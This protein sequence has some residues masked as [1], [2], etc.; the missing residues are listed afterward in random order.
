MSP[1]GAGDAF[2]AG[3]LYSLLEG[4]EELALRRGCAMAALARES[5]GDYVVGGLEALQERMGNEGGKKLS[6]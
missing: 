5:R 6:R 2:A 1:I 3:V 4:E